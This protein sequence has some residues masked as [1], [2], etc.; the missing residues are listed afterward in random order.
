[1]E[2]EKGKIQ[3]SVVQYSVMGINIKGGIV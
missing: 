2:T 1:M 3:M